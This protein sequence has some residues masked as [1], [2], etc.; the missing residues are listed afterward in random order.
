[1]LM[2]KAYTYILLCCDGTY[3]TGSTK[4]L[5]LRM[6]EHY[7]GEGANYTS[8]RLPVKLIYV[9]E[10]DRIDHAFEREK[11]IQGWSH[12]KK[13]AL[14]ERNYDNLKKYSKSY[15]MLEK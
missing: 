13:K 14:I 11:Q 2:A 9:E 15:Q 6:V 1:M 8:K 4:D 7:S 5:H 3:Y 10:F 12:R